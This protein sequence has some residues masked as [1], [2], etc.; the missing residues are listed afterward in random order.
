MIRI[1]QQNSADSAKR[2]YATA[3]Y[4]SQGQ[5]TIGRWGGKGANPLGLEGQVDKSAFDRLCDNL[6]PQTGS[7]LTVRTKRDRT[8][9]YDFTFSVPKSISLIY[10]LTGDESLLTAFR[11]AVDETMR[12]IESEMQTRVR[13][14]GREENRR[15]GNLIWAEFIHTTS[16]PVDGMP[17]PHLHAHLFVFNTTFDSQENPWKAGQFREIKRDAPYFQA[18]FRVRLANKLQALGYGVTRKRDD[19]ELT[20]LP[21]GLLKRFS[22]RTTMIDEMARQRGIDDPDAK[23]LLGAESRERKK[24]ELS[25]EELRDQWFTQLSSDERKLIEKV[26]ER[27]FPP[28]A[29]ESMESQAVDYAIDHLFVRDSVVADRKILTEALKRGLGTVTVESTASQLNQ[30]PLIRMSSEDGRIMT[31]TPELVDLERRMIDFARSGRGRFRPLGNPERVMRRE[32][33][34]PAQQAAVRHVLASRDRVT[35]IRGVAGTGKTSLEQELGEALQ[36]E[37]LSVVALAPS[38]KASR[39]V[40]REQAGFAD[41]ETVARF[42]KDEALQETARDGVILVDEA[43]LLGA[44]DICQLFAIAESIRARIVLVGDRRQHRSVSAG[45]PLRLLEEEAGLPVAEV[46]EIL[47]QRGEYKK[48]V[49]SLSKGHAV[50]GLEQLD[51]LGW[52]Q[53]L[54]SDQRYATLAQSYLEAINQAKRDGTAKTALIVSPT[55][56][57][58]A[59]VTREIRKQLT[60]QGRLQGERLIKV[61]KPAHW[62]DAQ[63]ADPTLYSE[64]DLIQFHQNARGFT[65][66]ERLIITPETKVPLESADRY[67]VYHAAELPV[68]IGDRIR[69]TASGKTRDGHR[70][71]NGSLYTVTG[72]TRS[73]DLIV[74]K[75]IFI[76]RDFGHFTHGYV[77]TSHASQGSTVDQVFIAISGASLAAT[78]QRTAYVAVS[79]GKEKAVIFTEDKTELLEAVKRLEQPLSATD[80]T[81]ALRKE[82]IGRNQ[83]AIKPNSSREPPHVR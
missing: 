63:K 51:R 45:E 69:I 70:L 18:A 27:H 75:G 79:R 38:I 48:A 52:V 11:A 22:R 59:E 21:A 32:W 3:D 54:D 20:G 25:M 28:E 37:G 49:E 6:H 76:D 12:E 66:S 68:A 23:A 42:L 44:R 36:E 61:W 67:Q 31:T 53:E 35:M 17:D 29:R 1:S 16:R 43:S 30:R 15:T 50:T 74:D 77:T 7:P 73:G 56:A 26:A 39:G 41:A 5:E 58:S 4:Y 34:N 83:Q 62:T 14:S 57:E 40:L 72:F 46:T 60:H 10:G 47:R 71:I 9:G 24:S 55:H 81:K 33:L 8:I 13:Q 78:D 80:I 82:L 65:K 19:F 2:Y 64:G